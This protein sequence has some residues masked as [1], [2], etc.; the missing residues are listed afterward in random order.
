MQRIPA[1]LAPII[2]F[3]SLAYEALVR[4]H[5][6]LYAN[7]L[8]SQNRLPAPVISIGNLTMGG[9]G[10][11]PLVIYVARMLAK[12]G[13]DPAILSRG[14]RRQY[15]NELRIIPPEETILSP[16]IM[17]GDEPALIRRHLASA[18]MGIC[19]NRF[20]AGSNIAKL[21]AGIVFVLD[22]G[23]QHRELHRDLDIVVIDRTQPLRT[24]RLF[25]RGTL[26]EPLSALRRCHMVVINGIPDGKPDLLE[27]EIRSLH[28][29]ASI[30]N[31]I[32]SIHS[33]IPFSSW[34]DSLTSG[35]PGGG[36]KS[37]YVAT[38]LGNPLR[39]CDDVRKSGVE[40]R[41]YSFFRDHHRLQKRDWLACMEDARSKGVEAIITT[42]KDAIKITQPP[43]FPLL[44]AVQTTRM[45]DEDAFELAMKKCLKE[46]V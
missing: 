11:T 29:G 13:F 43:D 34:K 33:L 26:R 19:K 7:G 45:S 14:Y 31:C 28:S 15:P 36:V 22:D 21:H 39:F 8:L 41:G 40:V 20:E 32:Q 42:E 16:A 10:K 5:A 27:E 1:A 38:A 24:N 35:D 30:F 2:Y 4:V 12:L 37:A 23:F 25:P 44:V 17:L 18:W 46:R 3:P 9:S 6:F